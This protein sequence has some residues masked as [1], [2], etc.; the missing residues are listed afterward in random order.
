M[1]R[2]SLKRIAAIG[3]FA[4]FSIFLWSAVQAQEEPPETLPPGGGCMTQGCHQELTQPQF[5][6]GPVNLKQCDPCNVPVGNKHNFTARATGRELCFICHE[7]EPE[8][9]VM[10]DPFSADCSV[11]HDPHGAE[12]RYFV[13]G[14]PGAEGCNV[15]HTDVREG[16]DHIHGPVALGECLACH[17]PHQSDHE[18]LLIEARS[19][20]CLGCHV[21]VEENLQAAVS[22][23]EPVQEKCEGCHEAHGGTTEYFLPAT[24]QDLCR[25]CHGDF[26]QKVNEYEY[27]HQPMVEGQTCQNCHEAHSSN[28]EAL[29]QGNVGEL[30]LSCHNESLQGPRGSI[31]NVAAQIEGAEFLHGPL[32]ENN[33]SACHSAHGSDHPEILDMAFPADF[34]AEYEEG[35]YALC[36]NCHDQQI[37]RE[38]TT[39]VTAFR[40]GN[41]NLHYVH[42]NREKGRSC[43]SCHHEHAS[44]QPNHVRS[45][46]PFGRWVM[47]IDFNQTDS[48]GGCTTGC[49]LPY[50]YDRQ[51][52]VDNT[53]KF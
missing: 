51:N 8:K 26:L 6:H 36:F 12:N 27:T 2:K 34:Y 45:E 39:T 22:V 4:A 46:V 31:D 5:L 28:Q 17:T 37:V 35:K 15:C 7:T 24:G 21:D 40:N 14:G 20:L 9:D 50:K 47:E 1:F 48:G 11:C 53:V 38:E 16:L 13:K 25:D 33:C 42:V 43:R 19:D 32:R 44:N 41:R 3:A 30:C 18:G 23:H 49:H 29:L 10:H 52:P